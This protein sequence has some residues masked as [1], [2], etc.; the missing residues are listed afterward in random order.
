MMKVLSMVLVLLLRLFVTNACTEFRLT[1]EDNSVVVG[2]SMEFFDVG[3]DLVVEPEQYPHIAIPK[4][5][6]TVHSPSLL[7]WKNKYSIAYVNA[8]DLPVATDGF[9]EAGL[10]VATNLFVGFAHFQ[11]IPVEKCHTAV[12]SLQLPL[13]ILGNFGTVQELRDA[14]KKDTFP[15]VFEF[16]LPE[17]VKKILQLH[18]S[19]VDAS[20]DAIVIEFTEQGRMVFDNTLGILTNSPPYDFH[21]M[22]VRNYVELSKSAHDSL[23]LGKMTFEAT[24]Q[25]SGLLGIPGDFTP[26]SRFVRAAVMAHFSDQVQTGKDAVI[27]A[28]H[29]LNTVDIPRGTS[30]DYTVWSVVKDLTTKSLYF[31]F[32]DDLTICVLHMNDVKKDKRLKMK[33]NE[34]IGGFVNIAK[35]LKLAMVHDEL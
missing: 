35:D 14:L 30:F 21:L 18:Y 19:I 8:L 17:K 27:K 12:S 28:F 11:K 15:L 29:I 2:R 9:N 23:V 13:W 1:S 16:N 6:C 4:K 3:Y 31:R 26:P 20:G 33:M 24:G 10:S 22:N 34:C 25:G 5:E 7:Q 32:Y